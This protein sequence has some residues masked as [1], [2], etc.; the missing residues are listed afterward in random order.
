MDSGI[1]DIVTGVLGLLGLFGLPVAAAVPAIT[2]VI[3]GLEKR[4]ENKRKKYV[5]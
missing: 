5:E 2:Q 3:T 1:V 4:K